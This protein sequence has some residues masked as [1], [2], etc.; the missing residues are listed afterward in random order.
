MTISLIYETL[1]GLY[2]TVLLFGTKIHI[3][4]RRFNGTA[5]IKF[6]YSRY[7]YTHSVCLK[8]E[9]SYKLF[10]HNSF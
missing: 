3:G 7:V 6:I 8:Q 9:I 1:T 4:H 10:D 2:N 5:H